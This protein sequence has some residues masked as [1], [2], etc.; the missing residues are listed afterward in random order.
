MKHQF[1]MFD[2]ATIGVTSHS[3]ASY[4]VVSGAPNQVIDTL[5]RQRCETALSE[6]GPVFIPVG[7]EVGLL[8]NHYYHVSDPEGQSGSSGSQTAALPANPAARRFATRRLAAI[9]DALAVDELRKALGLS[10]QEASVR[11]RLGVLIESATRNAEHLESGTADLYCYLDWLCANPANRQINGQMP[12]SI[13]NP[14]AAVEGI[15]LM[16]HELILI[17]EAL[18]DE[19]CS[20]E[21]SSWAFEMYFGNDGRF[22][23]AAGR[24][25]GKIRSVLGDELYDS[26][27]TPIADRW[28]ARYAEAERDKVY[29]EWCGRAESADLFVHYGTCEICDA[30]A[31]Q[32][33]RECESLSLYLAELRDLV[34][35]SRQRP[36]GIRTG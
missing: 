22:M 13:T 24:R 31:D 35:R 34:E 29:C 5:L 15:T 6:F 4:T 27:V 8:A 18:F 33:H 10:E 30:E 9:K 1:D 16:T 28:R 20:C 36:T 3:V 32:I 25:L 19:S 14:D 23:A 26:I 17:A 21:F 12:G 7:Y 11:S 2:N